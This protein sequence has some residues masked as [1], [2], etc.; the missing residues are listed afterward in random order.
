MVGDTGTPAS[1]APPVVEGDGEAHP[2]K[3][4]VRETKRATRAR[5]GLFGVEFTLAR[6]RAL[7]CVF[8]NAAS[9]A[10]FVPCPVFEELRT[11]AVQSRQWGPALI[12]P[13]LHVI[14]HLN[15]RESP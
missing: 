12:G 9:H 15:R 2:V 13:E 7:V 11:A 10:A 6:R 5:L 8:D 3:N 4:H 1:A 14:D